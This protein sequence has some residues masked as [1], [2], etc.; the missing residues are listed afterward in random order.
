MHTAHTPSKSLSIGWMLNVYEQECEYVCV[1]MIK[2]HSY[3]CHLYCCCCHCHCCYC[4]L[5]SYHSMLYS[6]RPVAV[7]LLESS[8]MCSNECESKCFYSLIR[9]IHTGCDVMWCTVYVRGGCSMDAMIQDISI[10]WWSMMVQ[11]Q[12]AMNGFYLFHFISFLYEIFSLSPS[13]GRATWILTAHIHTPPQWHM[14]R[15][16]SST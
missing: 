2:M 1:Y 5:N 8:T 9:Y 3:I 6:V 10:L 13:R 11:V 15:I 12:H 14:R 16:F 7:R 4:C